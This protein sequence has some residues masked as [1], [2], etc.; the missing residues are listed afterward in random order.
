MN[1]KIL[2]IGGGGHCKSVLDSLL[3]LDEYDDIGIIDTKEN[4]GK[5]V[6]GTPILG[7]DRDLPS[8]YKDGYHYAFVAVGSIGNPSVRI[9][10]FNTLCEMGFIIPNIVDASAKVS[11]HSQIDKGVFI[12]KHVVVNAGAVIGQGAIIN[13]G[14]IVEHDCEIGEFVHIAPGTVLCGGVKIGRHSHIGTNSTVKQGIHI[15]SNC[16]IGMGS[17][18]T[19]KIRDNVIAYGNPCRDV[20]NL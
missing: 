2:L 5:A 14:A 4:V 11:K 17:V 3:D 7:Y 16:L 20:K 9:R 12:G 15:G 18:V 6:L 1:K 8:L 13:S 10:L 19:K